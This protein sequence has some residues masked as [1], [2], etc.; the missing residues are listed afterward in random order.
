MIRRPPRS[1]LF[2]YTTLFRSTIE[3]YE[4]LP[5]ALARNHELLNG[6]LVAVSGNTGRHNDLRDLMEHLLTAFIEEHAIGGKVL[7]E[8]EYD[9][10]ND[11]THAP[12]VSYFP[13]AKK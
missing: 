2:P 5:D 3:D 9:F 11:T 6:E 1:T 10:G 13:A 7:S 4:T 8:Q 12:D